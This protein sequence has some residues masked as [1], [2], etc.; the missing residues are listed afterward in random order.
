[1]PAHSS[2]PL[3][4]PAAVGL[5]IATAI[6]L[7][8]CSAAPGATPS[9]RPSPS[10]AATATPV[11]VAS[12]APSPSLDAGPVDFASWVEIQGFG[13]SSGL[14]EVRKG[15]EWIRDHP[16]EG[17]AFDIESTNRLV[18][19]LA[20]WL[21]EHAATPCWSDYHATM[22]ASL[23]RIRDGFAAAAEARA[24]GRTVPADVAVQLA[25]ESKAAFDLPKPESC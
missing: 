14:N 2:R 20:A 15:A 11:A 6:A 21:D 23:D 24:A 3:A 16:G 13:G 4:P 1:M 22:R 9:P 12:T 17:N 7:M 19:E 25:A 10:P 8:A 5:L 18:V